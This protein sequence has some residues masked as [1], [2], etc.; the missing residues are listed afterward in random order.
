MENNSYFQKAHFLNNFRETFLVEKSG[1]EIKEK[2]SISLQK[3]VDEITKY[4]TELEILKGKI[5][6]EPTKKCD[7]Y[8]LADGFDDKIEN[9][10]MVYDIKDTQCNEDLKYDYNY[11]VIRLIECIIEKVMMQT[12]LNSY[13]DNKVYKLTL[14]EASMLGF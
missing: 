5:G 13:P 7:H 8:W 6:E 12:I 9:L 10:P 1:K 3:E 11:I 4:R 14:K 2:V